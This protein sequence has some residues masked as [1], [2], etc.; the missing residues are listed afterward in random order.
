MFVP[1]AI[2]PMV[3]GPEARYLWTRQMVGLM[4]AAFT[5]L[6]QLVPHVYVKYGE[7]QAQ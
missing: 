6:M 2:Q 5:V 7:V 1:C 3:K 4:E